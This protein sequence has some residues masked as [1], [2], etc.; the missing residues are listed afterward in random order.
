MKEIEFAPPLGSVYVEIDEQPEV[1]T[2]SGLHLQSNKDPRRNQTATV[3][4]IEGD[5]EDVSVGDTIIF[6]MSRAV[7]VGGKVFSFYQVATFSDLGMVCMKA[8]C[9]DFFLN[10]VRNSCIGSNHRAVLGTGSD[11]Y[12]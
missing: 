3:V 10:G 5:I 8:H 12:R 11:A 7:K 2:G 6:N 9:C 1:K 4:E